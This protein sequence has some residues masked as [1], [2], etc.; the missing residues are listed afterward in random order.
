MQF[1]MNKYFKSIPILACALFFGT[2]NA[3]VFAGWVTSD[4]LG[5]SSDD[6]WGYVN[7]SMTNGAG[8]GYGLWTDPN[9]HSGMKYLNYNIGSTSTTVGVCIELHTSPASGNSGNTDTR[10][11]AQNGATTFRSVSDDQA[12][13]NYTSLLRYWIRANAPPGLNF[14][15]QGYS[16]SYNNLDFYLS[17]MKILVTSA[18]ACQLSGYPFLDGSS[19]DY[20]AFIGTN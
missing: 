5:N 14:R 12:P 20:P 13:G 18:S 9:G 8:Q 10:I 2:S 15:V 7:L 6:V 17:A 19:G 1:R 11:Y 3:D 4:G 16:S